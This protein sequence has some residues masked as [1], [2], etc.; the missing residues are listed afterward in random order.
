MPESLLGVLLGPNLSM[1]RPLAM[2][3]CSATLPCRKSPVESAL[4]STLRV[5]G[6]P[7]EPA[8]CV[9]L[10]L[11]AKFPSPTQMHYQP[12][13]NRLAALRCR[14]CTRFIE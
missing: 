8:E 6:T 12:C 13:L 9:C 3:N 2:S 1:A 11:L 4:D 14:R 7:N 10:K 5:D